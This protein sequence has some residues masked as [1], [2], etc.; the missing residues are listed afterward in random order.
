[1]LR[2]FSA[3]QQSEHYSYEM[4]ETNAR[5]QK[6]HNDM[7]SLP[8]PRLVTKMAIPTIVSTLVMSLYNMADTYFVSS[9]GTAATGAV[10]VNLTLMSFLSML[11]TTLALGANSYI[12]RLLGQQKYKEAKQVLSF[13][14]FLSVGIGL[15]VMAFG[16]LYV[17]P[18]VQLMGAKEDVI[19]PA[20]EYATYI[21]MAAPFMMGVF[22]LNQCLRAEGSAVLSMIGVLSGVALNL[23][24][25]PIFIHVLHWGVAG[26]AIATAISKIVS[27]IFLIVPYLC[28]KTVI[29][30][31][32]RNFVV[33]WGTIA[34]LF[35][36]G[37]PTL[38]RTALTTLATGMLNNVASA[39]S[40]SAL[41]AIS[42]SNRIM[43]LL[44]SV[45]LGFAQ[46]YQPV[47]GFN[48]GAKQY[49][50]VYRA[51]WFSAVASV[52]ST[53]AFSVLAYIFAPQLMQLFSKEDLEMIE[54]G[55]MA[56]RIQCIVMPSVAW[57]IVVNMT[58]AGLGKAVGAALLSIIRQ[59][60]F[61]IPMLYL[62]PRLFGVNGLAAVQGAADVQ[63]FLFCIP[64]SIHILRDIRGHERQVTKQLEEQEL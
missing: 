28:K 4:M 22:V 11:G 16:L 17:T 44:G 21:L 9:L 56:M 48:W 29:E 1:M 52:L 47:A 12:A 49:D 39:I 58:Y 50:R 57:V 31:K 62:L 25:D 36:M 43:V 46:G 10:G 61:F 59:G 24:L 53:A 14:F 41:A 26:A 35:K 7:M 2:L 30:L 13:T 63:S 38:A 45:V 42:V 5:Q 19:R 23:V 34:E 40:T 8:I 15:L 18:I 27:F 37:F 33:R 3:N 64:F 32:L 55:I 60:I 20:I 6:R 54:I 51:F